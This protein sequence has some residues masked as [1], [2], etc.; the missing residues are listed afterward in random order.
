L[1]TFKPIPLDDE[2]FLQHTAYGMTK[3]ILEPIQKIIQHD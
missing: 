2:K 1:N 3:T